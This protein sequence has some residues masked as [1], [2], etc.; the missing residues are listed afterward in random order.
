MNCNDTNLEKNQFF[1][2]YCFNDLYHRNFNFLFQSKDIAIFI[3]IFIDYF[4]NSSKQMIN[5]SCLV[6]PKSLILFIQFET[7]FEKIH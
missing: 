6:F 1:L 3:E 5:H 4:E 2:Q 7:S